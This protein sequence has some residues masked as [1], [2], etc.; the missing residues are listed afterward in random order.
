LTSPLET[1][2]SC[3]LENAPSQ[4][5]PLSGRHLTSD[6][7]F[8]DPDAAAR[9]LL[10]IAN[11]VEAVRDGRIHIEKINWPFLRG[12]PTEYKAALDL[13]IARGWLWLLFN[14][15]TFNC[16][17]VATVGRGFKASWSVALGH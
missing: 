7:H 10:E 6:R 17:R 16:S 2:L 3:Y 14:Q 13:A 1:I 11:S 8:T 15:P 9:K 4:F 12:T 5:Q